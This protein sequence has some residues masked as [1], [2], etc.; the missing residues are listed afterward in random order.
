[1]FIL[2]HVL[3]V[4]LCHAFFLNNFYRNLSGEKEQVNPKITLNIIRKGMRIFFREP[5]VQITILAIYFSL[6]IFNFTDII[7]YDFFIWMVYVIFVVRVLIKS[8]AAGYLSVSIFIF[9]LH[10]I[11]IIFVFFEIRSSKQINVTIFIISLVFLFFKKPTL[12]LCRSK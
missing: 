8:I 7:V 3:M 5:L 10:V 12:L 4:A 6:L 1:M 11:S 9:I 2:T